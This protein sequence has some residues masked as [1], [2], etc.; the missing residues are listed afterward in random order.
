LTP[1]AYL[2]GILRHIGLDWDESVL[3]H[4]ERPHGEIFAG[5]AIGDTD[6][7]RAIDTRSIGHSNRHLSELQIRLIEGI[8]GDLARTLDSLST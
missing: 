7:A 1:G 8:A 5:K 4:H 3:Q 2:P 6:P